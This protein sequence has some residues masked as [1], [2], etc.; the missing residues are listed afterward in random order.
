MHRVQRVPSTDKLGRVHTSAVAVWALPSFPERDDSAADI[1]NMESD[2]YVNP[3]DVRIDLMR[4]GGAGG[5]NVNKTESAVRLTHAPTGVMVKMQDSRSQSQNRIDA[6]KLLRSRLAARR[7]EAREEEAARLRSAVLGSST[8]SRG[9]KI[10]TYNFTQNRCS[11]H[12]SG[13]DLYNLPDVLDGGES[14]DKIMAG[15]SSHL[16]EKALQ[17]L[18]AAEQ[19]AVEEEGNRAFCKSK[20]KTR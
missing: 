6:W 5:Q 15:V 19:A 20:S 4:A 12:R 14:L 18:I 3:Q 1:D 8:M 17:E 13:L 16:D 2:F 7:R 9:D 11:D 10:R